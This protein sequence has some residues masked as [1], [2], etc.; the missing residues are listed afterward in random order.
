MKA[1]FMASSRR[2]KVGSEIY[3]IDYLF[4]RVSKVLS[5]ISHSVVLLESISEE[6][7]LV[8]DH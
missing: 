8:Q 6:N 5:R 4:S 3:E 2:L 7:R 1:L